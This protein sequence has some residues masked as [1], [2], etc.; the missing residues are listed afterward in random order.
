MLKSKLPDLEIK[1]CQNELKK[2]MVRIAI[3]EEENKE[4]IHENLLLKKFAGNNVK[5]P[6]RKIEENKDE[7]YEVLKMNPDYKIGKNYPYP[8]RKII[9][10]KPK[11]KDDKTEPTQ[12]EEKLKDTP[13][14][15]YINC[16]FY[17]NVRLGKKTVK[18]HRIIAEQWIPNPENKPE[19]DHIN[20][21][22]LDNHKDNLRWVTKKENIE[23]RGSY[24][25]KDFV[26]V[27]KLPENSKQVK[28]YSKHKIENIFYDGND[29]Y[30]FETQNNLYRKLNWTEKKGKETKKGTI[31]TTKVVQH[32][33]INFY[34]SVLD[35]M[36][37][38]GKLEPIPKPIEEPIPEPIEE[39]SSSSSSTEEESSDENLYPDAYFSF[40]L[41]RNGEDY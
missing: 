25:K 15:E 36:M 16:I 13:V 8:I 11:K 3:L 32:D 31:N 23:N 26:R 2:A 22:P 39:S 10:E 1:H 5:E 24:G 9:K 19:V 7:D 18:K 14:T 33:K 40:D 27:K 35:R 4:L 17:V 6:D 12:K 38:E 28:K 21:N 37:Q 29:L 30:K 34:K 20:T 41:T